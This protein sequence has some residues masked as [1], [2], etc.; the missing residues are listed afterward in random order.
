MDKYNLWVDHK[1]SQQFRSLKRAC[2]AAVDAF[3][4]TD[5]QEVS[6]SHDDLG[7]RYFHLTHPLYTRGR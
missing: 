4:Q 3:E 5:A 7:T 6:V 1:F 2:A